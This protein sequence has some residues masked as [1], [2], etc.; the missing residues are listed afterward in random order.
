MSE[1]KCL[2]YRADGRCADDG[3]GCVFDDCMS[4]CPD[5]VPEGGTACWRC[6]EDGVCSHD[7]QFCRMNDR[8]EECPMCEEVG[9]AADV[10][11]ETVRTPPSVSEA[12]SYPIP[13]GQGSLPEETLEDGRL[14]IVYLPVGVIDHRPGNRDIGD[15]G[16][17]ADSIRAEGIH[18]PLNVVPHIEGLPG[19]YTAVAGHRRLE[20]AKKAGLEEVP[21]IVRELD[22]A[23]RITMMISENVQRKG[24]TPLEE[25]EAIGQLMLVLPEGTTTAEVA[26]RTG[27]SETTVRRRRKLAELPRELVQEADARG[28]TLE[29]YEKLGTVKNPERKAEVL[30]ALGT[31]DFGRKLQLAQKQE[32]QDRARERIIK[33][34]EKKGAKLVTD[35]EARS[36]KLKC[37]WAIQNWQVVNASVG[38]MA[39]D[40]EWFYTVGYS[41]ICLYKQEKS[42]EQAEVREKSDAEQAREEL[43]AVKATVTEQLQGLENEMTQMAQ[44]FLNLREAFVEGFG[45]FERHREEIMEFA[46][47]AMIHSCYWSDDA[48]KELGQWLGAD[49]E[50]GEALSRAIRQCPERMLLLTSYCLMEKDGHSWVTKSYDTTVCT[51]VVQH[52]KEPRLDRIYEGL[53]LL[54]YGMSSDEKKLQKGELPQFDQAKLL[55][56]HFKTVRK[57]LDKRIHA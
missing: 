48:K 16:E 24:M 43:A 5:Y 49:P 33:S 50:D 40:E 28:A 15:V 6:G 20:A 32:E 46:V 25:A 9:A 2:R 44:D 52:Q 37:V 55:V 1:K 30:A 57:D 21:C 56:E 39:R 10:A 38:K 3:M 17:L 14:R 47:K 31:E 22:E 4:E 36:R 29:D 12:D 45:L 53:E 34:L 18:T 19:R 41:G 26:R 35:A 51:R 7:G 27:L 42:K 23:A 11:E 8:V 13:A 54:G